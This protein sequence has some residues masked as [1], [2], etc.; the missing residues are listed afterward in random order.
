MSQDI[1]SHIKNLADFRNRHEN[2]RDAYNKKRKPD[3]RLRR[4]IDNIRYTSF[5]YIK[6]NNLHQYLAFGVSTPQH[7]AEFNDFESISDFDENME[8][9]INNLK[10]K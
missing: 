9:I 1:K 3:K 6:T 5:S 2:Q 8:A 10:S 4:E 7:L